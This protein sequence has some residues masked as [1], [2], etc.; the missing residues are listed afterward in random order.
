[1]AKS[2][3]AYVRGNTAAFYAWIKGCDLAKSI[4]IGPPIWICGDCHIGNLG[5]VADAS[6]EIE[7]Q[8]R[9]LDQTVIGNPAFDILRLAL[10]LAMAARSSDLPGVTAA[11]MVENVI[12]GYRRGL[13]GRK[14]RKELQ[15]APVRKVMRS[16]LNRRWKHLA[17]ERIRDTKPTI[18]EGQKFWRLPEDEYTQVA[19]LFSKAGRETLRSISSHETKKVK[20]FDAAYWMKG[21]SSLGRVRYAVLIGVGTKA[22]RKFRLMDVKEAVK[23]LAPTVKGGKMPADNAQR[24]VAGAM[25]LSPFLGERMDASTLNGHQVVIREL[26]PQDLKFEFEDL[27]QAEASATALLLAQVVGKAHGRQMTAAAR[28]TWSKTLKSSESARLNAPSWLWNS[29]VHLVSEHEGAYL[30]HCRKFALQE[31]KRG[32]RST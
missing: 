29:I 27:S 6:G 20:V 10:S 31:A 13:Q 18:P 7:I 5:P 32:A 14:P 26:R 21:C 2:A 23:A 9:D 24:V 8:I 28:K 4:P 12:A 16:A 17:A 30:S 19:D 11:V 15:V 22:K 3:H 1:M 25:A